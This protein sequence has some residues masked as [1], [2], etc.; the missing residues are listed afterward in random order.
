MDELSAEE[1]AAGPGDAA[2]VCWRVG[3]AQ[4]K[5]PVSDGPRW[6]GAC[7][8]GRRR[9]ADGHVWSGCS[10]GPRV[11]EMRRAHVAGGKLPLWASRCLAGSALRLTAQP[12]VA[13]AVLGGGSLAHVGAGLPS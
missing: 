3:S 1:L 6:K 5:G 11:S 10:L 7:Q 2:G 9:H 13:P 8:G 4:A 12:C